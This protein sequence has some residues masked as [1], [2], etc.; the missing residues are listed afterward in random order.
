MASGIIAVLLL[1][2]VSAALIDGLHLL[3]LRQRCLEIASAA[4]LQGISRGRDYAYYLV[5]GQIALDAVTARDEATNAADA[6][7]TALGLS[8]YTIRVE[9]LDAP[10][11]GSVADFPPG[12]TWTESQ[13]AVGVYLDVPGSTLFMQ[14]V[15]G[16]PVALR[17]FAAAGVETE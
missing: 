11:G 9:V 5:T 13:P 14:A 2:A 16:A 10:G 7:L 15:T 4:A 1:I 8:G 12:Q 17:V 6:A 3:T